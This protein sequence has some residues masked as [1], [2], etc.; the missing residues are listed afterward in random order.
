V[1]G[2]ATVTYTTGSL[3]AWGLAIVI[4]CAILCFISYRS[5]YRKGENKAV[6]DIDSM[7][8]RPLKQKLNDYRRTQSQS[9]VQN[10]NRSKKK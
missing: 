9:N 5:G 3:V 10:R 2:P 1:A 7:E 8:Q 6:R 4:G